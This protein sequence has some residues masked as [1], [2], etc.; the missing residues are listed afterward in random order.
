MQFQDHPRDFLISPRALLVS[1][2]YT[3]PSP[4]SRGSE[5]DDAA[6]T[7]ENKAQCVLL[8]CRRTLLLPRGPKPGT[9]GGQAQQSST[10]TRE[11]VWF[12]VRARART[13]MHTA[14]QNVRQYAKEA[15]GRRRVASRHGR[16]DGALE[17]D[18]WRLYSS[19]RVSGVR[20]PEGKPSPLRHARVFDMPCA[21]SM[22]TPTQP[23]HG[24]WVFSST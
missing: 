23:S 9:D 7:D 11:I 17:R 16:A 3:R 8:G 4:G 2:L 15:K 18:G 22:H 20:S 13:H 14:C 5:A 24:V 12:E 19:V 21:R 6:V 1:Y 10:P